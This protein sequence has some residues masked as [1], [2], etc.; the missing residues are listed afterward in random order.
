[1]QINLRPRIESAIWNRELAS[2]PPLTRHLTRLARL[3]HLSARG[4]RADNCSLRASALT[5]YTLLSIVPVV[6]MLFG[7]AKGFGFEARLQTL[8]LENFQAQEQVV[9][10]IIEFAQ[11]LLENTRGG[12]IA[13]IG[14]AMLFWSVMKVLGYIETTFNRIWKIERPRSLA[15]KFTDYL[16]VTLVSPVLFL[17]AG[18][19]TIYITHRIISLAEQMALPEFVNPVL[20][21]ALKYFPYCLIWALLTFIYI[22]M[23]NTRVRPLSALLG[24]V[25]AG[26]A[27]QALQLG[28]VWFQIALSKFNAIYGSFAALPLFLIW[29]Q[30]SWLIVLAGA[31]IAY[32]HQTLDLYALDPR[33]REIGGRSLKLTALRVA[34]AIVKNFGAAAPPVTERELAMAVSAPRH[35]VAR[36]IRE[37]SACGI[38]CAV[39]REGAPLPAWLPALDPARLTIAEV[40]F[41]LDRKQEAHAAESHHRE[42]PDEEWR[43]IGDALEGFDRLAESAPENRLLKDL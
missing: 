20:F 3:V 36:A 18:S 38:I 10:R 24:G 28:Y 7:I 21:T 15:R 23:P 4:F 22:I 17:M 30:I 27:Y 35:Q 12:M 9:T 1:M 25:L 42:A 29:L 43:A 2:L 11:R 31:E 37:L 19:L 16:S 33:G 41:A 5:Y 39:R 14:V 34:C 40:L 6:A 8:L 32:A 13:G 26:T